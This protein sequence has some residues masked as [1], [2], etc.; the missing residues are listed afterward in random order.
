MSRLLQALSGGI[1]EFGDELTVDSSGRVVRATTATDTRIGTAMTAAR[2]ADQIVRY[3]PYI[4]D[5]KV[6]ELMCDKVVGEEAA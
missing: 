3:T 4:G 2:E 6:I 5:R 1:I